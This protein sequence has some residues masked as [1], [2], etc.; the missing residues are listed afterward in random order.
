VGLEK[1]EGSVISKRQQKDLIPVLSPVG[2]CLRS[3]WTRRSR[4][5]GPRLSG[6]CDSELWKLLFG[7]AIR[8]I[9]IFTDAGSQEETSSQVRV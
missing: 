7:E 9:V 2:L 1:F 8:R 3:A 5:P 6:R 4:E